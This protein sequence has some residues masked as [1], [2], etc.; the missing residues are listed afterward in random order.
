MDVFIA[1]VHQLAV[2]GMQHFVGP[3][4]HDDDA[5]MGVD[6]TDLIG[7]RL[8]HEVPNRHI[9]GDP[10][11]RIGVQSSVLLRRHVGSPVL[12]VPTKI[13]N[14]LHWQEHLGVGFQPLIHRRRSAF[15]RA[16]NEEIRCSHG[17]F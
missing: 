3:P 13:M 7:G 1:A 6:R 14:F 8:T 16:D 9:T 11:A 12:Q 5:S 17:R 10:L 4:Q 2:K 15:W